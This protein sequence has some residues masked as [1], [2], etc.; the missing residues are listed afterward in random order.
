MDTNDKRLGR[1]FFRATST[2]YGGSQVR[3]RIG[4]VAAYLHH[5]H[6][7]SEPH[8]QPTPQAHEN[9]RSLTHWARP[10]IKPVS[11]WMP[12]VFVSTEPWRELPIWVVLR[13]KGHDAFASESLW[14]FMP[15]TCEAVSNFTFFNLAQYSKVGCSQ[16]MQAFTKKNHVAFFLFFLFDSC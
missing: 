1:F 7:R 5:S 16:A 9:T 4:A 10:R 15:Y 3:G 2:A 13:C 14:A 12:V 6:A 8:L 11:P